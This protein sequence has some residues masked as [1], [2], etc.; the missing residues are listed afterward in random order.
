M[1]NEACAW[2]RDADKE[3]GKMELLLYYYRIEDER[4]TFCVHICMRRRVEEIPMLGLTE[5]NHKF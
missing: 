5:S 4:L 1:R 2:K 3:L